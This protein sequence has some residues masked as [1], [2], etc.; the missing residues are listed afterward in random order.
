MTR[1]VNFRRY[2]AFA[3]VVGP[4]LIFVAFLCYALGW[5]AWSIIPLVVATILLLAFP[6]RR[7]VE[8]R[9]KDASSGRGTWSD[10]LLRAGVISLC[11]YWLVSFPE[12]MPLID[13]VFS[14]EGLR[15][16]RLILAVFI[17]TGHLSYSRFRSVYAL[18]DREIL[19]IYSNE[20]DLGRAEAEPDR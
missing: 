16:W 19:A 20:I 3:S 9:A 12:F 11:I 10:T 2:M 15:D 13:R 6:C 17:W 14:I 1:F 4:L 5:R 18:E 8:P 7:V